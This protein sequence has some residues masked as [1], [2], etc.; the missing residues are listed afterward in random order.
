GGPVITS[1][2]FQGNT[3]DLS[4]E[5]LRSGVV[6]TRDLS[7]DRGAVLGSFDLPLTSRREGFLSKI[8]DISL[9]FNFEVEH[10]SDFGTMRTLGYGVRWS[11]IDILDLAVSI[12]A[13]DGAPSVSQ[14]G[15]P[16]IVTP[17]VRVFDFVRGETV[18][19]TSITGGN[20]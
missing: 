17:N 20:P 19:V 6:T 13:E 10:L 16:T 12:T 1:L 9:N 11:P 2:T 14:L 7:R 18:D 4:S 3:L 5:T 15:D 8:G